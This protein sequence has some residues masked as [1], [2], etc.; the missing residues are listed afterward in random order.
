LKQTK[1]SES[2]L[3]DLVPEFYS[4]D[5]VLAWMAEAVMKEYFGEILGSQWIFHPETGEM[6]KKWWAQGNRYDIF[7][8]M[9][10]NNF[11]P[12]EP[13]GLLKQWQKVLC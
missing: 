11:G 4:L 7:Q 2:Y 8:F 13:E 12:L 9:E 10:H 1:H 6:L 5:Y 3:F